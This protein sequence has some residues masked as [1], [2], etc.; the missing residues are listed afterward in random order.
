MAKKQIKDYSEESS[1]QSNDLYLMQDASTDDYKKVQGSNVVP[2]NSVTLDKIATSD[3]TGFCVTRSSAQSGI[4]DVTWTV[5][6]FDTEQYDVGSDFNTSNNRYIAPRDGIY[7]FYASTAVTSSVQTLQLRLVSDTTVDLSPKGGAGATLVSGNF[8][9]D[10][11]CSHS[12]SFRLSSGDYVEA[13]VYANI[14]AGTITLSNTQFAG[15]L[16]TP[17]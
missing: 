3:A 11:Q 2:A 15:H 7:T 1:V 10:L 5:L 13:Q 9:S 8:Q 14:S 16:V 12:F 6:D 4:A 17:L